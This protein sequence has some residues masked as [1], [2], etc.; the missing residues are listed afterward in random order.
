[1]KTK[2]NLETIVRIQEK[3]YFGTWLSNPQNS[4]KMQKW[5]LGCN[6]IVANTQ[7]SL[8]IWKFLLH[9][10]Y[11]EVFYKTTTLIFSELHS[12]IIP[13][14]TTWHRRNARSICW[15]Y[16]VAHQP[17]LK[18]ILAVGGKGEATEASG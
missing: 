8:F 1:M 14:S 17:I 5:C 4:H 12:E 10:C 2:S 6:F 13:R 7:L 15:Q 16:I 3:R 11:V 18:S 9:V